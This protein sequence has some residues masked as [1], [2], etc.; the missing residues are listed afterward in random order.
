VLAY[1][2]QAVTLESLISKLLSQLTI[3]GNGLLSSNLY[4]SEILI[5]QS[6]VFVFPT[7][8]PLYMMISGTLAT[9]F[10]ISATKISCLPLVNIYPSPSLSL[11]EQNTLA[12]KRIP[13]SFTPDF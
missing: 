8:L 4:F 9:T 3:F 6:T 10:D 13:D 7:D 1:V 12:K 2:R 5:S 11:S